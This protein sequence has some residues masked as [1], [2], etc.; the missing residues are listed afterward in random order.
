MARHVLDTGANGVSLQLEY[1]ALVDAATG[2]AIGVSTSSV[3]F[4][5]LEL[6]LVTT[7]KSFSDSSNKLVVSGSSVVA[8][9]VVNSSISMAAH[10]QKR[11]V[12]LTPATLPLAYGSAINAAVGATLTGIE[13]T[14]TLTGSYVQVAPPRAPGI[15][16]VPR[17]S[18]GGGNCTITGNQ[19]NPAAPGFWEF[20]DIALETDGAW[21]IWLQYGAPGGTILKT[22]TPVTNHS[23]RTRSRSR[24]SSG[25]SPYGTSGYLYTAPAAHIDV[26]AVRMT[27]DS[28]LVEI[29]WTPKARHVGSTDIYRSLN[30]GSYE[31]LRSVAGNVTEAMDSLTQQSTGKYYVVVRTPQGVNQMTAT[32][33]PSPLVPRST[34][35]PNRPTV[36]TLAYLTDVAAT[37]RVFG[38]DTDPT[39]LKYWEFI[40]YQVQLDE[41]DW[42]A[43][44]SVAGNLATITVPGLMADARFKV[45]VRSRNAGGSSPWAE[46]GYV[47]TT[48][49]APSSAEATKLPGRNIVRLK[50]NNV[51]AW[52]V[53]VSVERSRVEDEWVPIATL[54]PG[55]VYQDHLR[56]DRSALYRFS[57]V[58]PSPARRS[59]YVTRL[60]EGIFVS[61]KDGIP[62]V[63]RIYHGPD[64]VR[65]VLVGTSYAWTDGD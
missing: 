44:R 63:A 21:N 16:S 3:K 40:D 27:P 9:T 41:L 13:Y 31:F 54:G 26:R 35:R 36:A 7:T 15:P 39:S 10:Q 18:I 64:R 5:T 53:D 4:S 46:T 29:K 60:A 43:T 34:Q 32:S 2:G 57:T 17:V 61:N 28:S 55:E 23:Y 8:A 42:G 51:S 45:R 14:G 6:W 49:A 56:D 50:A 30:G 1:G 52:G 25:T 24:N 59:S 12:T 33:E 19:N 20:Q 22:W 38:A 11:L 65:Q 47:F 58:S 62:G 37:L 48:P